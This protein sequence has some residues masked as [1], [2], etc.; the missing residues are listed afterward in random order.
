MARWKKT[1]NAFNENAFSKS[2]PGYPA[3]VFSKRGVVRRCEINV[4]E[5]HGIISPREI[6]GGRKGHEASAEKPALEQGDAS[7]W[8]RGMINVAPIAEQRCIAFRN[9]I[10]HMRE[11]RYFR[12]QIE[13]SVRQVSLSRSRR[14]SATKTPGESSSSIYQPPPI[15]QGQNRFSHEIRI[16]GT[17]YVCKK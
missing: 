2:F 10:M 15:Q 5:R 14:G 9:C 16:R 3:A 11:R 8:V 17:K 12:L 6:Q 13:T 7:E 1:A 4:H